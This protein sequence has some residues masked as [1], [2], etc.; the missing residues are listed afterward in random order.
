MSCSQILKEKG[1]RLTPQ[2]LMVLSALH[3]V[4]THISAEDIYAHVKAKYQYA[5]IS[6]VYRTLDLL[7]ELKLITEIDLDDGCVRYHLT[8]K[9]HHHHLVCNNCG[10]MIDLPESTLLK[11]SET[12]A[13]E[14]QF[15]ADL[16][17]LAVFGT[18]S[19]CQVG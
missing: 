14:Y 3:S 10:K 8:E 16:K 9:G 7:K 4:E 19:D 15:Q 1:Y 5:N 11:L 12:L 18:C 17:H 13:M 2:R 6:T